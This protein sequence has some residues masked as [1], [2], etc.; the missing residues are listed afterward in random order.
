MS[1]AASFHKK[2]NASELAYSPIY[3]TL[4]PGEHVPASWAGFCIH[5]RAIFP[6]CTPI[7]S[8]KIDQSRPP[9]SSERE[10]ETKIASYVKSGKQLNLANAI[11]MKYFFDDHQHHHE[12]K[13]FSIVDI[14]V[15]PLDKKLHKKLWCHKQWDPSYRGILQKHHFY[16]R[17]EDFTGR[18]FPFSRKFHR[19]S[20][21][22]D[23]IT[24]RD[25]QHIGKSLRCTVL[26]TET[27]HTAMMSRQ[28]IPF[29]MEIT[30]NLHKKWL[31]H[32]QE[33]GRLSTQSDDVT[34]R[35]FQ[36][37]GKSLKLTLLFRTSQLGNFHYQE[38]P[39]DIDN[40]SEDS[41]CC[42]NTNCIPRTK[43]VRGILWFSRCY[44][45]AAASAAAS[46][47]TSSFSR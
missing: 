25:F 19:L 21:Q 28:E 2:K 31:H 39:M 30:Q 13:S 10:S 41:F 37:I 33:T 43:Y 16:T 27:S 5:L 3:G 12:M 35:D 20:T 47:D 15:V 17:S 32:W 9:S 29:S 7:Y 46:A 18:K 1:K 4:V 24:S 22:S 11:K 38:N 36:H 14:H 26:S 45:A 8:E 34:S 42:T 40:N 6:G 23:D 44:A